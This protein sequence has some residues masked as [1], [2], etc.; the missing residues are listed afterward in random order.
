MLKFIVNTEHNT[1]MTRKALEGLQLLQFLFK[2]FIKAE[3]YEQLS[4]F[5]LLFHFLDNLKF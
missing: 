2:G 1:F 3:V 5:H 4:L